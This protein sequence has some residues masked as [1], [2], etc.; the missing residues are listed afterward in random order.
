MAAYMGSSQLFWP[1]DKAYLVL[2]TEVHVFTPPALSMVG[3]SP[4]FQFRCLTRVTQMICGLAFF[5]S[6]SFSFLHIAKMLQ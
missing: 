4:R 2:G 6:F 5:F 1:K 3:S